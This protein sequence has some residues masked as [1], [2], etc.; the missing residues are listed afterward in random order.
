MAGRINLEATCTPAWYIASIFSIYVCL[1]A[2]VVMAIDPSVLAWERRQRV[3]A[4]STDSK[5]PFSFKR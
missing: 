3:A 5:S 2:S 4:A 1:A